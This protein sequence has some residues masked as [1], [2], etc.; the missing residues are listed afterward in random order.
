MTFEAIRSVTGMSDEETDTLNLL[1]KQLDDR[2]PRNLLRASVYDGKRALRQV[3]TVI[4]PQYYRMGLV[5]G[6][7]PKG[8]DSLARRCN[9]ERFTWADGDLDSLGARQVQDQN[10]LKTEINS[11]ITST[12]IHS[13]SF[14]VTV[15]GEED[16]PE[17]LILAR[18]ALNAT[19]QWNVRKRGLENFVSVTAREED[20][21]TTITLYLDGVTISI[22]K[23]QT[24]WRVIEGGRSEHT[25]GVPVEPLVYRPRL[26]RPFGSSR[27]T[28]PAMAHQDA[29]L[30]TLIRLEGHMD[31]YSMPEL[32]L[33]GADGS[34]FKDEQGNTLPAWQVMLGRIKGIPDDEDA[35]N[36]RADVRQ[37]SAS[38]PDPQLANLN[39]QAKLCARE[40]SLPDNALAIT[41]VS[42]PT[43]AE[44]YDA[45][46][47][48]LIA[49]AEGAVVDWSTPLNRTMIRAL[50][51]Q[52]GETSIPAEWSSIN[53]KWRNP[54]YLT[55]AAEADAG[56]KQLG[57][58][59]WLAETEVG[60][61]LLGLTDDQMRRALADK[62]RAEA[63]QR[64]RLLANA[65]GVAGPEQA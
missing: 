3:G 31:I 11:A 62:R 57:A 6:W 4:P 45:A 55:R 52:N 10:F 53:A 25:W 5:L 24:G 46:Q 59:P 15:Q 21:P 27:I 2:R 38:S 43:S 23:A 28:R 39:A 47:Y 54:Q 7:V 33:L 16:E 64:L 30:R 34:V 49:E 32:L 61:E 36:P 51:I 13:V 1:L 50:A 63:T 41:D 60:L 26:G 9:L 8:V 58:V 44:S 14:L 40:M 20:R 29:G 37:I 42:N 17:A 56:A 22:E 48:E 19:G 35:A 12:L 18:D 65:S